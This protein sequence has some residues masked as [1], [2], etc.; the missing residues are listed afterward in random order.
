[1]VLTY[2]FT[3]S[4]YDTTGN[5]D[6][7]LFDIASDERAIVTDV[8]AERLFVQSGAE[9]NGETYSPAVIPS[10]GGALGSG[11]FRFFYNQRLLDTG[12]EIFRYYT[13]GV[14]VIPQMQF[15]IG[16]AGATAKGLSTSTIVPTPPGQAQFTFP[17]SINGHSIICSITADT[18]NTLVSGSMTLTP[19]LWWPY[20]GTEDPSP[21]Y[22]ASTGAILPGK[23]PFT[24]VF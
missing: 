22:D 21:I 7:F 20:S 12:P 9:I 8:G 16:F 4:S 23:T 13:D 18:I 15:I 3:N 5:W 14:S 19:F 24:Q 11:Q 17:G 2:Q 10:P 1:M 6:T